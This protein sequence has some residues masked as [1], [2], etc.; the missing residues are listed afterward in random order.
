ME[1]IPTDS[2]EIAKEAA[3]DHYLGM[4]LIIKADQN[5]YSR[6]I[7]SLKNQHNQNIQGYLVN[8]QQAYQMLVDYVPTSNILSHMTTTEEESHIYNM[9]RTRLLT[10]SVIVHLALDKVG[11]DAMVVVVEVIVLVVVI[12][13]KLVISLRPYLMIAKHQ[14]PILCLLYMT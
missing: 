12:M 3:R 14:N 7:A 2:W 10:Q 4:M 5:Q 11:A 9:M 6:L 13:G 1:R 8:R